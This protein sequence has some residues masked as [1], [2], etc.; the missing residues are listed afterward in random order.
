MEQKQLQKI[1]QEIS[2]NCALAEEQMERIQ[3]AIEIT[4]EVITEVAEIIAKA[5]QR[6]CEVILPVIT[7]VV[8]KIGQ[9]YEAVLR[10]YP[11]RRVVWLAF[12]H[13][14]KRVRKKNK[15]RILRW[16]FREGRC[17]Q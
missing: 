8:G 1:L 7:E 11:N 12:H 14:R 17:L 2:P 4:A 6:I 15:A 3:K 16:L 13:K 5:L 10:T 9:Y